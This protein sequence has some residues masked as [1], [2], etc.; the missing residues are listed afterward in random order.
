MTK[1]DINQL[2]K[3]VGQEEFDY[4]LLATALSPYVAVGQKINQLLKSGSIVQVK[5]GLYVFGPEVRQMPICK[6]A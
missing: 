4:S 6:A 2:R 1:V 5:K 3:S